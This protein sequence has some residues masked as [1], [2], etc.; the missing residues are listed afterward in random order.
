MKITSRIDRVEKIVTEEEKVIQLELSE[1]QA[2]FLFCWL[3]QT[4]PHGMIEGI[5]ESIT[6]YHHHLSKFK[7]NLL[8]VVYLNKTFLTPI[9][10]GLGKVL[11]P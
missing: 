6:E 10:D 7:D 1:E 9:Y 2:V 5:N 11:T 3:G 8:D 4:A